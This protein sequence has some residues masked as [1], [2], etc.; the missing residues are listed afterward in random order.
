MADQR[1]LQQSS[2]SAESV[3]SKLQ[4][5]LADLQEEMLDKRINIGPVQELLL[6]GVFVMLKTLGR[7]LDPWFHTEPEPQ[8]GPGGACYPSGRMLRIFVSLNRSEIG[9]S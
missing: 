4:E 2:E 8:G 6:T 1:S 3:I 7:H 5:K 9:C